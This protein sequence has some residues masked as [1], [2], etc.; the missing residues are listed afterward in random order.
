MDSISS[1]QA[2]ASNVWFSVNRGS[3]VSGGRDVPTRCACAKAWPCCSICRALNN[4]ARNGG[5]LSAECSVALLR[6]NR[7]IHSGAASSEGQ[8]MGFMTID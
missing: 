8:S 7:S 5:S 6:V 1:A 3:K 2:W 4:S